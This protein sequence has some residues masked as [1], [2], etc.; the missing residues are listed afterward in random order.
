MFASIVEFFRERKLLLGL[1]IAVSV[2]LFATTMSIWTYN[3]SDVSRLDVSRP[4]DE[5]IRRSL[6]KNEEQVRFD[7]TGKLDTAATDDFQKLFD[8]KRAALSGVGTFEADVL[9]DE[10]LNLATSE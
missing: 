8:E 2:A 1:M 5:N 9:T 4:G 3:L 7:A 10:R 6:L